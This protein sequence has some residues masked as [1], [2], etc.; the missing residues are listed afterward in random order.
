PSNKITIVEGRGRVGGRLETDQGV[1]V[2]GAWS[3]V[4]AHP[5]VPALA[6][7]FGVS[8]FPQFDEG[9]HVIDHGQGKAVTR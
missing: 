3:W 4:S 6:R 5:A 1:D 9:L 8:P 2:G 7:R